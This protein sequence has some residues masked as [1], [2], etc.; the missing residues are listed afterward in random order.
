MTVQN[1]DVVIRALTPGDAPAV[2][3]LHRSQIASGFLSSLG[4][5][6]LRSIYDA[7]PR[8][9]NGFGFVAESGGH[10]VGF[11]SCATEL[12]RTYRGILRRKGL[13][14]GLRLL[15]RAFHPRTVR[16]VIQTVLYPG[17]VEREHY[18]PA[19]LLSVVTSPAVRGQGVG[20]RLMRAALDEFRARGCRQVK[21]L[22]GQGLEPANSYYVRCG[23][24]L[25]GKLEHHE[26]RENIYIIELGPSS[27]G[28]D[29][30]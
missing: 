22:V 11:V 20:G 12:R 4:V 26:R 2:A 30:E 29:E 8:T 16:H 13:L 19:E 6:V 21:V 28:K 15:P 27:V 14:L 10:V 3:E 17:T 24:R 1:G 5:G 9:K 18:P 7:L 23:F 25:V